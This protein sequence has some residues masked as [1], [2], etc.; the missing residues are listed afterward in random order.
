MHM[1]T[2]IALI[3]AV[4]ALILFATVA[5]G[6]KWEL[7]EKRASPCHALCWKTAAPAT[8]VVWGE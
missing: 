3:L 6:W 4:L 7:G 5:A 2:K 8:G 1:K